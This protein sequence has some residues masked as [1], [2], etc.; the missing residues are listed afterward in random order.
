[1]ATKVAALAIAAVVS[2]GD[3]FIA[4]EGGGGYGASGACHR[5]ASAPI[6]SARLPGVEAV[7]LACS[8]ARTRNLW[9]AAWGGERLRGEPP[10]ADRLA[11]LARRRAVRLI[12][13]TAG[14]NDVGF[15]RIVARCA[16]DWARSP[17]RRPRHCRQRAQGEVAAALPALRRDLV[18]A[19]RGIRAA[20]AAA[21]RGRGD[22]RLVV[23]GYASPF[24]EGRLIRYPEH[25]WS[26][27]REGGCPVWNADA[28]WAVRRAVPEIDAAMHAAAQAVGAEYLDLQHALDGHQLCDRRAVVEWVRP[29]RFAPWALRESL[30]PDARGQRAIGVCI[31][32]HL[33]RSRG[34]HA[35]R[36][37]PR[38]GAMRLEGLG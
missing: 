21:G 6:H 14:A 35:C 33:A 17:L 20:M 38:G 37:S 25:G 26:R 31:A 5:S 10:Q 19:L 22:Y 34:D 1:M 32:L 15:G 7:N 36:S 9:P 29:L 4:G 13:V 3:S 16:L 27:L 30:H 12:V 18:R 8:G 2:I 11:A 24:P 28:D 23:M